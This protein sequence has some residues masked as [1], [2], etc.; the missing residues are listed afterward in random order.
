VW[1]VSIDGGAPVA[2][3]PTDDR[4]HYFKPSYSPDGSRIIV[5]CGPRDALNEDLCVANADGS[6]IDILIETPD[7]ENHGVWS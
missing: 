1:T 2:L 4:F 7:Y 5:G 3:L 6:G